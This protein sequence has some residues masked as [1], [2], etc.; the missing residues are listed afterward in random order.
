MKTLST[1]DESDDE[2]EDLPV[3]N[4]YAELCTRRYGDVTMVGTHNSAFVQRNSLAANQELSVHDQLDDGVR[5]LQAQMH[6]A[7]N[8]LEPH[9]CHTSCD[10]LDAG[11]ITDWLGQV[12]DWVE[13]HPRDVVT[14]LLGNGN[15]AR[16]EM[17]APYIEST[18]LVDFAYA[19]SNPPVNLQ[20]WPTLGKMIDS[21][22]RVVMML[23]YKA[24]ET[25]YPWLL[26]EFSYMWE[27]PFDP[28]IN[29]GIPC[30]TQ[31]P[32]N[33]SDEQA[34]NMLYLLNH[35]INIEVSLA[36]QSV[37]IPA[38]SIAN[39]TNAATGRNSLGETAE[40]CREEWTRPPTVLNVDYYNHGHPPGSVFQVAARMNRVTYNTTC[41]RKA[42]TSGA[43]HSVALSPAALGLVV[44]MTVQFFM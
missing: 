38:V 35:N 39:Q 10:L 30:S 25:V 1:E 23:D 14:I 21:R 2:T 5:F 34:S 6:W 26:D 44:I 17:Y 29:S 12:K 32:P 41:C 4:G 31:R 20:D 27:T 19:P 15:Y 8:D 18:G 16:P 33:L 22:Q 3:C 37:L 28:L 40:K 43:I 24:D 42:R 13:R 7:R 11:P 9:F 36:G